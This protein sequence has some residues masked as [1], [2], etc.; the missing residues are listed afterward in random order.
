MYF[1]VYYLIFCLS[2]MTDLTLT[3]GCWVT[4]WFVNCAIWRREGNLAPKD[5]FTWFKIKNAL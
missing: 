1:T 3:G 2:D 5:C 4:D